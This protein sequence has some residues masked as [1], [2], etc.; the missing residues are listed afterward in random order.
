M[1]TQHIDYFIRHCRRS[2]LIV[3]GTSTSPRYIVTKNSTINLPDSAMRFR[4][5]WSSTNLK[6][7]HSQHA[8]K[9]K[10]HPLLSLLV[11]ERFR[12]KSR[13]WKR[14]REKRK[15][16]VRD[17]VKR[18]WLTGGIGQEEIRGN[19]FAEDETRACS[20]AKHEQLVEIAERRA[21]HRAKRYV[22]ERQLKEKRFNFN[23]L[24][25]EWG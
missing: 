11:I 22:G 5:S 6:R 24:Y 2:F 1:F 16:E 13:S 9:Q 25:T 10:S 21:W 12:A 18:D 19:A 7:K 3:T 23:Q 14:T 17:T 4:F 15:T 20:C 8:S